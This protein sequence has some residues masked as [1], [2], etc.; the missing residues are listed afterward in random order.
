MCVCV[1]VC[2]VGGGG[3]GGGGVIVHFVSSGLLFVTAFFFC[4]RSVPKCLYCVTTPQRL[5]H[6]ISWRAVCVGGGR[7]DTGVVMR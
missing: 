2:C 4:F 1:C 7:G 6:L 3:A 5:S